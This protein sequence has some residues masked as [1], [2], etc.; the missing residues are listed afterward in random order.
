[1]DIVPLNGATAAS[2]AVTEH[3]KTSSQISVRE[4][5]KL[6]PSLGDEC[7]SFLNDGVKPGQN[8]GSLTGQNI[9]CDNLYVSR[10]HVHYGLFINSLFLVVGVSQ[11]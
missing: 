4:L 8:E 1:M 2:D 11:P 10:S 6:A 9:S 3:L 7:P 5:V